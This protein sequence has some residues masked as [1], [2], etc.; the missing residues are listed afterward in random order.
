MSPPDI[1]SRIVMASSGVCVARFCRDHGKSHAEA[2]PGHFRRI[3]AACAVAA[4]HPSGYSQPHWGSRDRTYRLFALGALQPAVR[5]K[6][7]AF[8]WWT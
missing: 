4:I 6:L 8:Q 2:W 7:W 1:S 3:P 5:L